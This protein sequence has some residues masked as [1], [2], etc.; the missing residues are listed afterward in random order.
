[1]NQSI[2]VWEAFAEERGLHF[3]PPADYP[4]DELAIVGRLD[5]I[6]LSITTRRHT[7]GEPET[8]VRAVARH[9]MLGR[10]E[11]RTPRFGDRAV[12]LLRGRVSLGEPDL[13]AELSTFTS[14]AP[15]LHAIL[16]SRLVDTLRALKDNPRLELVYEDGAITIRWSGVER[17]PQRLDAAINLAVHLAVSVPAR[18]ASPYR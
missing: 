13:D 10:V 3:T 5:G 15:L 7:K 8:R 17:A 18:E 16:D 4:N 9:A 11:I 6:D 14:S 1:M 2:R 12:G